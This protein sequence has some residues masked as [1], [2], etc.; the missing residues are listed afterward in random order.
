[1]Y[2]KV[3]KDLCVKTINERQHPAPTGHTDV[4][5]LSYYVPTKV[6]VGSR[7]VTLSMDPF[8]ALYTLTNKL[9][10]MALCVSNPGRTGDPGAGS[11]VVTHNGAARKEAKVG[12]SDRIAD[13][14]LC[15]LGKIT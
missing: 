13:L 11:H 15:S 10:L 1:M 2:R 14:F 6:G 9:S 8:S 7:A 12:G 4:W 3:E 5:K